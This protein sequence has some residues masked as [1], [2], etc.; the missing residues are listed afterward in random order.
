LPTG[1]VKLDFGD[2]TNTTANIA[3]ITYTT[4]A[5]VWPP[6]EIVNPV[7]TAPP[8]NPPVPLP[9][10]ERRGYGMN[11][12]GRIAYARVAI[13]LVDKQRSSYPPGWHYLGA[14]GTRDAYIGPDDLVYKVCTFSRDVRNTNDVELETF[15]LARKH[16]KPWCPKFAM[17]AGVII[18]PKYRH[19]T[20]K[21]TFDPDYIKK[22][23][24]VSILVRD[25]GW[26]NFGIDETGE[27]ILL[28]G[29]AG[30]SLR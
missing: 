27:L 15:Q 8:T 23:R 17:K 19:I 11:R 9:S 5:F 1:Y 12:L 26:Q 7:P 22:R 13:T 3:Y 21:E 2:N 25:T 29:G 24:E 18:M 6:P 30:S 20:S 14:G 28:D 10:K 4:G 16:K